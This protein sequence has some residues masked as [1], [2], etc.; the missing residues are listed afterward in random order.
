MWSVGEHNVQKGDVKICLQPVKSRWQRTRLVVSPPHRKAHQYGL[1]LRARR[2]GR[3]WIAWVSERDIREGANR[4]M[5]QDG[6]S[7]RFFALECDLLGL[8]KDKYIGR[9]ILM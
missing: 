9:H 8:N 2:Q 3:A 7:G 5:P 6:G 1:I 4:Q